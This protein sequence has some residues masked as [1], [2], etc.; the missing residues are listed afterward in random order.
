MSKC[1]SKNCIKIAIFN[2]PNETKWL[3]CKEHKKENMIDIKN[4]SCTE[5]DCKT[6]PR[7]A[8]PQASQAPVVRVPSFF[9][10]KLKLT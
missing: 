6:R 2:L 8:G 9:L 7:Q 3:Y 10:N 5:P 1:I 4:K